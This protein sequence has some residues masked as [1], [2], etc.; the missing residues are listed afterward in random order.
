MNIT[1]HLGE[2][3]LSIT[4]L[5]ENSPVQFDQVYFQFEDEPDLFPY[6]QDDVSVCIIELDTLP[7][8]NQV[9]NSSISERNKPKYEN[10][11]NKVPSDINIDTLGDLLGNLK[12]KD[13]SSISE[14]RKSDSSQ[15]KIIPREFS[16]KSVKSLS[17]EMIIVE[18]DSSADFFDEKLEGS[19]VQLEKTQNLNIEVKTVLRNRIKDNEEYARFSEIAAGDQTNH[20]TD[21]D[22]LK[23]TLFS[24]KERAAFVKSAMI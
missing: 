13:G 22:T 23:E 14:K 2:I 24:C 9:E 18:H 4:N 15:N 5:A 3:E 7:S 11:S 16:V 1:P 17:S 12:I 20:E 19:D 10:D 6:F 21:L 8:Q